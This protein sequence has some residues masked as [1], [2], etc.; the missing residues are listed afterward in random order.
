M[1]YRH[2][3][4]VQEAATRLVTPA[5][6]EA[7]LPVVIGTAPV[8]NLPDGVEAPINK[9]VLVHNLDAFKAAFGDVPEGENPENYTLTQA[10]EVYLERY[11]VEPLVAINVFDPHLHRDGEDNPDVTQVRDVDI[12]GGVNAQRVRSG[13]ALVHEIFPRFRLTP[14]TLLAPRYSGDPTVAIALAAAAREVS[15]FFRAHAVIDVPDEVPDYTQVA[16]WLND[17]NL[18][19]HNLSCVYGNCLY[20]GH[21]EPGSIHFAGCCGVRDAASDDVPFWSPSNTSLL[22]EGLVHAGRELH[23]TAEEAAYLN[24]NGIVTG[25]NM[26]GGL[27]CWGDQTACY[28]GVTDVK[29]SSIPIRRMFNWIGNTLI[30]TSWQFVSNPLRRRLVETVQDTFNCWLNGLTAREY[31]LGGRVTFELVDNPKLDLLDGKV[32]WHVYVSPP[33]AARELD[34]ILEYDPDYLDTLF[35]SNA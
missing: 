9:P 8:H 4:Y 21:V 13:I 33:P 30:K 12:V 14:A 26:I 27:K 17:N 16:A 3:V 2:G 18:T 34:F 29:D 22:C 25:L 31:I 10:A 24:G 20:A 11:A 5:T 7:T 1:S 35:G 6:A 15:G 19:Q 32:R 28:P 23:L